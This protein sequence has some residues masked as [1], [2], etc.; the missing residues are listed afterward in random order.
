L[1]DDL[2]I[3]TG[4][5][6]PEVEEGDVMREGKCTLTACVGKR[7]GCRVEG[8]EG[9]SLGCVIQFRFSVVF[10]VGV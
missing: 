10:V 8:G 3:N 7:E 2:E 4:I 6:T 9:S 1:G 5:K